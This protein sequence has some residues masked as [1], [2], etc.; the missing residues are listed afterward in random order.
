MN[1]FITPHSDVIGSASEESLFFA[2]MNADLI[3]SRWKTD[4]GQ[5]MLKALQGD[6]FSRDSIDASVGKLYGKYDLRGMPLAG[7]DLSGLDLS[8]IDFF[9]ANLA[10]ATLSRA[11]LKGSHFS[12]CDIRGTCFDWAQM[13]DALIDNARFDSHTSF[14]GVKLHVVNFTLATLLYDLALSQQRIQQL[15]QHHRLF[16]AFLRISSDYGRSIGRYMAWVILFVVVYAAIYW[17]LMAKSFLDCL[18]FSTVTFAT[19]GYGDILPVT[20]LEKLVVM[21]E[22]GIGYLMGGLLV[23]ILAKRVLG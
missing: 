22:I 10:E 12:E 3:Q 17:Q 16:A 11:N 7:F 8:G 1:L 9:S 18:Y 21:S 23:A 14:L 15:E 6:R 20:Q 19:V 13:D 2:T 5:A 4:A